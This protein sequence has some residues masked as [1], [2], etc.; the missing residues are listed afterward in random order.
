MRL[1]IFLRALP[2][3][4]RLSKSEVVR[5]IITVG[6]FFAIIHFG[7]SLIM[8]TISAWVSFGPQ[9][10]ESGW[11]TMLHSVPAVLLFFASFIAF[12]FA[13]KK[14]PLANVILLLILAVSVLCFAYETSNHLYQINLPVSHIGSEYSNYTIGLK[15]VYYNWWW[16]RKTNRIFPD[17]SNSNGIDEMK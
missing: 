1:E 12:M 14:R 7:V 9:G 4:A 6:S 15:E 17:N 13:C 16:Y 5:W 8:W 10:K 2:M 11:S 3:F